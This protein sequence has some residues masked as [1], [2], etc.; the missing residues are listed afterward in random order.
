[1]KIYS[2]SILVLEGD[3]PFY[4]YPLVSGVGKY[5]SCQDYLDRGAI[6][7]IN[8][9]I[10]CFVW[11]KRT[12]TQRI[13][14]RPKSQI[15]GFYKNPEQAISQEKAEEIVLA[16]SKDKPLCVYATGEL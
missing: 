14:V 13:I 1:M 16:M 5:N 9:T 15:V 10:S 6:P 12:T 4:H 2:A 8:L 7:Y 3:K 11:D